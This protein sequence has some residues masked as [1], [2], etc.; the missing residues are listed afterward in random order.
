MKTVTVTEIRDLINRIE[1]EPEPAQATGLDIDNALTLL[2]LLTRLEAE[3]LQ[4]EERPVSSIADQLAVRDAL[5]DE[6]LEACTKCVDA[7]AEEV[8]DAVLAEA[9]HAL[10]NIRDAVEAARA[11]V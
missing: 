7:V 6:L 4:A 9:R 1:A 10:Q 11:G 8:A 2:A 5:I 3:K